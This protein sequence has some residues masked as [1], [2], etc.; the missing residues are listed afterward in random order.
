MNDATFDDAPTVNQAH[1]SGDTL[2]VYVASLLRV[3]LM[4]AANSWIE[5]APTRA[6]ENVVGFVHVSTW[7]V[8][9]PVQRWMLARRIER[10]QAPSMVMS[11]T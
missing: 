5:N 6:A 1:P 3:M 11:A 9:R 2:C 7:V 8:E 10:V 4:Y